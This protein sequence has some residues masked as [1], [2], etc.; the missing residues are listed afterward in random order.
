MKGIWKSLKD[1][2]ADTKFYLEIRKTKKFEELTIGEY[3][4][5]QQ[6]KMDLIKFI[7]YS[8]FLT[9]P[10]MELLLPPYLLFLPN[11]LPSQF[12]TEKNVGEKNN[13]FL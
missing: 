7:P 6:I 8:L 10:F 3:L 13:K 1:L 9:V 4:K 5:I 12:L 2:K 11:S